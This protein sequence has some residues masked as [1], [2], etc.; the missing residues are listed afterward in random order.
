MKMTSQRT[1]GG[2]NIDAKSVIKLIEKKTCKKDL[3]KPLKI[4][5]RSLFLA[6]GSIFLQKTTP[7]AMGVANAFL[8]VLGHFRFAVVFFCLPRE[9]VSN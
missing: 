8:S 5:P 7:K 6:S 2:R 4:G 3:P 1:P 9:M